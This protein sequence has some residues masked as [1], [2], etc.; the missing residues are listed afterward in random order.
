[1]RPVQ[2]LTQAQ[3]RVLVVDDSA[4]MRSMLCKMLNAD[5]A[6]AV[7]DVAR[8]GEEAIAKVAELRPDVVTMDIEMPRMNGLDALSHI[9]RHFPTPVIMVSSLAQEAAAATMDALE[10]G[11]V[12]FVGKPGGSESLNMHQAGPELIE[13]VRR[14][15]VVSRVRLAAAGAAAP[16]APRPAAPVAKPPLSQ[17]AVRSNMVVAIGAST[18]GPKALSEVLPSLPGDFPAP[19]L[20]VQHMPPGFTNA[21]AENLDG[22]SALRVREA[23]AGDRLEPGLALIAPGNFH[24][25]VRQGGIVALNQ[26]EAVHHVRPAVDVLLRSVAQAYGSKA[27]AVVLTGMGVDGAA[28]AL[29]VKRQG[30]RVI[31]QDE[32][33]CVVYGMPAAVAEAGAADTVAPLSSIAAHIVREV[34]G[35]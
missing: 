18:G 10:R 23:R 15:A 34:S 2:P 14:A 19:I 27:L 21:L 5:P 31:A 17:A 1:M 12:D 35:R 3:V 26:E 32:G 6:I 30:G 11:A 33:S 8:N 9:M 29:E 22:L 7:V 24:M 28:G 20:V 25:T 4:F 16:A 13:K